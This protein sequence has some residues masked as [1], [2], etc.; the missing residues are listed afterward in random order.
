MTAPRPAIKAS[1]LHVR[2]YRE[3]MREQGLVKK[4]VWIRPEYAEEL[5]AIEK[6]MR[7]AERDAGIP[8]LPTQ[9]AEAGWTVAA[10][11][12]ALQQ[13]STVRDGRISVET[14]EGAEPSLHLVMHE[15]GDLSVF[16]A[17]GGEQILVEAYL[18]PVEDVVDPAA[19]NAHVLSTHVLLPLSTIGL[20]RIGGVAGYT[21][22]G[23]L[24]THSSLANLMFEI[25][26]LAENVISA[27]EAYRPFLRTATRR[28]A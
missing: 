16:L 12:H 7:D 25:E 15:Y 2:N 17:V 3:R 10:I 22:F 9:P 20:Q 1:T 23:A 8:Y 11:R 5:A 26:T 13:A 21:M 27:T 18:W 19:F 14:I 4:D 24:D 28:K 6:S